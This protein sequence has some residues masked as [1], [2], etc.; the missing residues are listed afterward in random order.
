MSGSHPL[1]PKQHELDWRAA[2]FPKEDDDGVR[3]GHGC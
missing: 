1:A 3:E 2:G